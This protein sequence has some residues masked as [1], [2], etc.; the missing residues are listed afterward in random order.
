MREIIRVERKRVLNNKKLFIILALV[1]MYSIFNCVN[2][3]TGYNIYNSSGSISIFA[4]DNLLDL[5][6]NGETVL[7]NEQLQ[8]IINRRDKG[9]YASYLYVARIILANYSDKKLADITNEDISRFYNRR[10]LNI[11][12]K[13]RQMQVFSDAQI[14]YLLSKAS[15]LNTPIKVGYAES[16]RNINNDMIDF[17][18]IILVILSIILLSVFGNDQKV[19]M[20]QLCLSTRYGKKTLIKAKILAGLEIGIGIYFISAL[21]FTLPNLIIFG[22]DGVNL[23]LQSNVTHFYSAY[24]ITYLQQYFLNVSMGFIAAFM[25]ISIVLFLTSA[26]E[27]ILSGAVLTV[28]LWV[29]M[30]AL[31]NNLISNFGISHYITNFLPYNI[32]NFSSY[33]N[34]CE[35]YSAFG[36]PILSA[37]WIIPAGF[38]ISVILL[39]FTFALNNI[40][41]EKKTL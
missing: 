4:K 10:L 33:Y 15:Q 25:M 12:D 29:L 21:L 40:K 31:P 35:L 27:H 3:Y 34:L 19:G 2:N 14:D 36:K 6:I 37:Y 20:E 13:F 22:V 39:A 16:W 9:G 28:F 23:P 8:K 17:M 11:E 41:L 32:T 18:P 38:L 26:A 30:L 5:K 7:N 1:F 24:N